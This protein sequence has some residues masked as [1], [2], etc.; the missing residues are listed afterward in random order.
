MTRVSQPTVEMLI[1][2]KKLKVKAAI[3]LWN[4]WLKSK[5]RELQTLPIMKIHCST[6]Q[7]PAQPGFALLKGY[8]ET[9][10]SAARQPGQPGQLR[11]GWNES[12]CVG[13]EPRMDWG[14]NVNDCSR[15]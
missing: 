4:V 13:A 1:A 14:G 2:S 9:Q 5:A 15:F 7:P 8:F 3:S 11:P 12:E 6:T 10:V